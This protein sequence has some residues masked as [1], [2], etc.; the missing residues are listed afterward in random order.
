[1]KIM[2]LATA[3]VLSLGVGSAYADSEGGSTAETLFTQ[4]QGV[5]PQAPV[6]NAPSDATGPKSRAVQ[7]A[8][9]DK[10]SQGVGAWLLR[11]FTLP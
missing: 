9:T 1:M 5:M 11:T 7:A 6:Q 3:A 2:I 10:R 4:I 8:A